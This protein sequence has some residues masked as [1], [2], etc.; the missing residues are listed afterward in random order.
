MVI[1]LAN[2][3]EK[4]AVLF[5]VATLTCLNHAEG[6]GGRVLNVLQLSTT[7][8]GDA[9]AA[10]NCSSQVRTAGALDWW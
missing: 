10:Q 2:C 4:H 6:G 1:R 3:S 8:V 5:H 9:Q 7:F